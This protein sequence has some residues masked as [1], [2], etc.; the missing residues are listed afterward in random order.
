MRYIAYGSMYTQEYII[1]VLLRMSIFLAIYL[2]N[3]IRFDFAKK[4]QKHIL[5][6]RQYYAFSNASLLAAQYHRKKNTNMAP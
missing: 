3:I 1:G 6:Q 4:L 5:G 2:S